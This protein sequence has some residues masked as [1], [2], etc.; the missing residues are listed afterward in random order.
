MFDN[1]SNELA[2]ASQLPKENPRGDPQEAAIL[3]RARGSQSLRTFAGK[4]HT[5]AG[6][7]SDLENAKRRMSRRIAEKLREIDPTSAATLD[8]LEK[9][10]RQP[11]PSGRRQRRF[12]VAGVL[13]A[14]RG[15]FDDA[16]GEETRSELAKGVQKICRWLSD[17]THKYPTAAQRR[18]LSITITSSGPL[19]RALDLS[20]GGAGLLRELLVCIADLVKQG[21]SVTHV[22]GAVPDG[23]VRLG[24]LAA[25][26][27]VLSRASGNCGTHPEQGASSKASLYHPCIGPATG[28]IDTLIIHAGSPPTVTA[29]L[30]VFARAG[31]EP[32][33]KLNVVSVRRRSA[34]AVDLYARDLDETAKPFFEWAEGNTPGRTVPEWQEIMRRRDTHRGDYWVV[35]STLLATL[36]PRPVAAMAYFGSMAV[37]D[38]RLRALTE[39]LQAGYDFH[40]VVSEEF[41]EEF[42]SVG[43]WPI[44]GKCAVPQEIRATSLSHVVRLL[45][46]HA[47]LRITVVSGSEGVLPEDVAW[48]V[49]G[50]ESRR[51]KAS[52]FGFCYGEAVDMSG[53]G[54]VNFATDDEYIVDE[55]EGRFRDVRRRAESSGR[56]GRVALD[57]WITRAERWFGAAATTKRETLKK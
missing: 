17:E 8:Q 38:A 9:D 23:R 46:R 36:M 27:E 4:L 26:L 54:H 16:P 3:R 45:D 11:L 55:F 14:L 42:V 10:R 33:P 24:S 12:T 31:E 7:L 40:Q 48:M 19:L 29:A 30:I 49:R 1:T 57:E 15:S 32:N 39:S 37:W 28:D 13:I 18:T 41:F 47:N 25:A 35:Q 20:S 43:R 5:S 34:E 52:V 44:T 21:V 22:W 56:D 53:H 2:N 51:S 50:P 6:H